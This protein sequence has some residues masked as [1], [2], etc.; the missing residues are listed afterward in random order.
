MELFRF[1]W[2]LGLRLRLS[3][4][5]FGKCGTGDGL[6]ND[7]DGQIDEDFADL[8]TPCDGDDAD[9]CTGGVIAF[10]PMERAT[11]HGQPGGSHRSV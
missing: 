6:D 3:G 4:R 9:A 7:C 10:R 5:L 11:L 2:G 8:G 1:V